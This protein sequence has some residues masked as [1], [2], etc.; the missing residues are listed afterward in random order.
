MKFIRFN[1]LCLASI[2]ILYS[3]K[4]KTQ[5]SLTSYN[6]VYASQSKN[7]LGSMPMGNGDIGSNIWVD[8]TG[9]LHLLIS[10]T[11]AYSEI[12]RL[13]KIG[14]V[15][16][17]ITPNILDATQFSQSLLVQQGVIKIN[18]NKNGKW[19]NLLCYVDANHPVI[20]VQGKS[21]IPIKVQVSNVIWRKQATPLVGHERHSGYGVAFRDTPFTKEKDTVLNYPNALIWAHQNKSSI[22][23]LTL[24][25]QNISNFNTI[26]HDPLL[27][28]N[29]GAI[30]NGKNFITKNEWAI[31]T[32][33]PTNKFD[34]Q[35]TILKKQ[36]SNIH[37]WANEIVALHKKIQVLNKNEQYQEHIQWWH[38]Y[39][40]QHYIIVH[41]KQDSNTTYKI[42]QGYLLQRY[43]NA[44]A[45]R[46]GMPIKFN[47]SIF[48]VAPDESLVEKKE[49][50]LDADFR[51][52]GANFWFQNT[53]IPYTTM[54][55]SG[56]FKLMK[57][58]FEMYTNSIPL[59][60]YR[61][62]KYFNHEGAYFPET[63]T[64]WGSY[65]NDN[66]GWNRSKFQDGVSENKYIRYYWQSGIEL[67]KMMFDYYEFTHDKALFENKF[68]PFVK[69]I[70]TFYTQHYKKD[71]TGKL[72]IQPAQALETYFEGMVNP[73]P[74]IDGLH[75]VLQK[76]DEYKSLVNDPLFEQNCKQLLAILPVLPN[77]KAADGSWVLSSGLNLGKRMNI[78]DPQLYAVFPYRIYGV[79]KPHLE[80]AINSF[81]KR[82]DF[83][84]NGWQQDGVN[85][86]M[87]GLTEDAR[88]IVSINFSNKHN[89]SRFPAFWGPN[90]DWVPDQDH[91]NITMRALQA[92]LVQ[93]EK[94]QIYLLPAWPKDWE[95][96]FKVNVMGNEQI[97]GSYHPQ[98]GV[99]LEKYN[100]KLP[101][102]I[103][104][105]Q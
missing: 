40:H 92:M 81:N 4:T 69:E 36:T 2:F 49:V 68:L 100:K 34:V 13:L 16:I 77:E 63:I 12:G 6:V 15:D 80:L 62:Q 66:Y 33:L 31:E 103:M 8:T 50:G 87:L 22:W 85:A 65:L 104:V 41:S 27:H 47:G 32:K 25:N 23:Q 105:T 48:T 90:Y 58:F 24:D 73:A 76:I 43:L 67:S 18:A 51:L 98:K 11:D 96:T 61:T 70:I 29:F 56:D 86:A 9:I 44:C 3:N 55:H 10:K 95:V 83:A 37:Q 21:N 14:Q 72:S 7:Q 89:G 28:Q 84:F 93:C 75:A 57:P 99:V 91:G 26:G 19:V 60:K 59:A 53:R 88:K 94:D 20:Q 52:W 78:E 38:N 39:W 46:G 17:K 71:T 79:G 35:I 5:P 54:Y 82:S 97:I 74:E 101:I 102:K 1:F 30:V 42:T 64:P 45:G